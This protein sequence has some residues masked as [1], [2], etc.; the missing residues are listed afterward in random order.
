MDNAPRIEQKELKEIINNENII[1]L[2]VRQNGDWEA[3]DSKILHALRAAPGEFNS[4][5]KKYP[6]DKKLMLYCS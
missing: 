4:W 6:K 1:I 5:F 2:D 3:S